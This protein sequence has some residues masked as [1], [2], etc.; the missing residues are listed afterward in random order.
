MSLV[1]GSILAAGLL[2]V[3]APW[4]WPDPIGVR[5]FIEGIGPISTLREMLQHAGLPGRFWAPFLVVCA[6]V[7]VVMAVVV[8]GLCQVLPL[9]IVVG[10]VGMVAPVVVLRTRSNGRRRVQRTLWPDV[11][12]HLVSGARSGLALPDSVAALAT[13]GPVILQPAFTEYVHDYRMTGNFAVC[14]DR[15]KTALA[16]PVADRIVE[17]LRMARDVGGT[18]LPIVLR[19]LAS[20][21]REDAAIRAE[22]EARQGWVRNAARLGVAAPWLILLLLASRPEAAAAYNSHEGAVLIVGGL[23]VSVLA[24]QAM[25]RVGRLQTERR[26]FR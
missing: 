18:D 7:G 12:D 8:H 9:T 17:T 1:V 3:A 4:L 13:V 26:W 11:V 14:L 22:A 20:Q 10:V 2:L 16:D 15:L 24:Y 5:A 6:V 21:L 23:I 25:L 19:T